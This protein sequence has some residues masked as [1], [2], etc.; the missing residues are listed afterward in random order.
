[1]IHVS[2]RFVSRNFTLNHVQHAR[3][4]DGRKVSIY[5]TIDISSIDLAQFSNSNNLV[6]MYATQLR[7]LFNVYIM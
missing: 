2:Y 3:Y 1:M 6:Y 7:F 4:R 5:Q